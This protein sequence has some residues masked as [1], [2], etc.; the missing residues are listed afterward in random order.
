MYQPAV[1]ISELIEDRNRYMCNP[2]GNKDQEEEI[3]F[4]KKEGR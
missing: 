2:K 1:I 3:K 4:Q